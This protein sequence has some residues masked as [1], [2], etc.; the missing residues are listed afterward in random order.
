M[1][2][3]GLGTG[4]M[5]LHMAW[6]SLAGGD[7]PLHVMVFQV[8][9]SALKCYVYMVICIYGNLAVVIMNDEVSRHK[10]IVRTT[11]GQFK[12]SYLYI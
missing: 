11:R 3:A 4:N 12:E 10:I 2:S 5:I 1:V 9:V 8:R 6:S 7:G